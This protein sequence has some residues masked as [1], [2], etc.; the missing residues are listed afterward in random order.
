MFAGQVK[1]VNHSSCRT[2]TKLKY[3]C[4]L[5]LQAEK[6]LE[7][8]DAVTPHMS[9]TDKILEDIVTP[10]CSQT[11]VSHNEEIAKL[12]TTVLGAQEEIQTGAGK[13]QCSLF[14]THLIIAWIWIYSKSVLSGHS[15]N[16]NNWFSRPIIA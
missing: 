4:P 10:P 1:I 3:F 5:Y 15:K 9:K 2:S 13:L 11:A 16:T 7:E 8:E 14:I 12:S 6:V